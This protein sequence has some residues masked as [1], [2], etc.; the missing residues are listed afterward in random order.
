MNTCDSILVPIAPG[1]LIDKITIL[2]IKRVRIAD[3]KKLQNVTRELSLLEGVRNKSLE[4]SSELDALA[5]E[6]HAVN[7]SLWEIEDDIRICELDQNFGPKFIELARS[8]YRTNDVRAGLKRKI[9]ELL[10]SSI[11]EEKHYVDYEGDARAK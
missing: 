7:E 2:K 11:L 5:K 1:E 10:G 4:P 3:E 6:L 9:N 8:V